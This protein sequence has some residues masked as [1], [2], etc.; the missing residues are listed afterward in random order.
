MNEIGSP[1]RQKD[2]IAIEYD[3]FERGSKCPT[4]EKMSKNIVNIDAY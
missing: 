3:I 2:M 1:R 4:D